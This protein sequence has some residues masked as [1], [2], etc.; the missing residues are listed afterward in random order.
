MQKYATDPD[1]TKA[2]GRLLSS[3]RGRAAAAVAAV[4]LSMLSTVAMAA[5][6]S[7]AT[8]KCFSASYS[9]K[10]GL[11]VSTFALTAKLGFCED[12]SKIV[13]TP[14]KYA[15]TGVKAGLGYDA[16][17]PCPQETVT[18]YTYNG[19]YHGGV[20]YHVA[21][22]WRGPGVKGGEIV[23]KSVVTDIYGHYDGTAYFSHTI[24]WGNHLT[25]SMPPVC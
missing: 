1:D 18:Y 7:A 9:V 13:P 20:H 2:T 16:P 3:V 19:H 4:L 5:P 12:G 24:S 6:A 14:I 21:A 10:T 23:S 11:S 25:P 22:Y 8:I 17:K 15:Y